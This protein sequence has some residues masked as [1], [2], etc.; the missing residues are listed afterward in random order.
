MVAQLG[1]AVDRRGHICLKGMGLCTELPH[2][3]SSAKM[4]AQGGTAACPHALPP[5]LRAKGNPDFYLKC[6]YFCFNQVTET[7]PPPKPFTIT[8][9]TAICE[10]SETARSENLALM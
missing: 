10:R 2:R 8:V 3:L 1:T 7:M 4:L 5:Y 6:P 9:T